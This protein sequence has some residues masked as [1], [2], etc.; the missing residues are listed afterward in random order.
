MA[1]QTA[2]ATRGVQAV[3]IS[4]WTKPQSVDM[5]DLR[6]RTQ[7]MIGSLEDDQ[8]LKVYTFTTS[9]IEDDNPFKPLTKEQVL[10][11]LDASEEDIRM[12]RVKDAHQAMNDI[13]K[14]LGMPM[15]NM[16]SA[17]SAVSGAKA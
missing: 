2:Q 6:Q 12:G 1:T 4:G 14:R 10:A 8:L 11:D 5:I 13:R 7:D 17:N 9:L 15:R 3:D 16:V